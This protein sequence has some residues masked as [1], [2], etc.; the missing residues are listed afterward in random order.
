[1][2][3]NSSSSMPPIIA[4]SF[5]AGM[6]DGVG[7][8]RSKICG[9][10]ERDL[11][12]LCSEQQSLGYNKR[13]CMLN[14]ASSR[15][16]TIAGSGVSGSSD[17]VGPA[18]TFSSADQGTWYCNDSARVCG[19]LVGDYGPNARI[20]FVV[21]E[22]ITQT[23]SYSVVSSSVIL[24]RTASSS[25]L[26]ATASNSTRHSVSLLSAAQ[27]AS[28]SHSRSPKS[29]SMTMS[30]QHTQSST[31]TATLS[32]NTTLS[33]GTLSMSTTPS[34]TR[35]LSKSTTRSLTSTMS[36]SLTFESRT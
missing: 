24:S 19:L 2:G 36:Y 8:S 29:Y 1:S 17:G 6:L 7:W 10:Y 13:I 11:D 3:E 22:R 35:C 23:V 30:P 34:P 25:E 5:T 26:L 15:V 9:S 20:R 4:G 14:L 32:A 28:T 31:P 33:F 18:A 21:V 27:S 16:T 12:L